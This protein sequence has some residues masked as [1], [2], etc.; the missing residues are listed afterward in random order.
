MEPCSAPAMPQKPELPLDVL[1]AVAE[2]E[3]KVRRLLE[4]CP[5]FTFPYS[6]IDLSVFPNRQGC[7]EGDRI[8]ADGRIGSIQ[9]AGRILR[10]AVGFLP[11]MA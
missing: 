9:N 3:S 10:I 7:G 1:V 2:I 4:L 5:T 11:G 6:L 8:H